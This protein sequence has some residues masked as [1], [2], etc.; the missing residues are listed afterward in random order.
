M[1]VP[2]VKFQRVFWRAGDGDISDEVL[3]GEDLRAEGV[4]LMVGGQR[5]GRMSDVVAI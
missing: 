2:A 3:V 1:L 5:C 4:D